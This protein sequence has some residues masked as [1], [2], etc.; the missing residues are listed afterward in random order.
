M[1]TASELV[2]RLTHICENAEL[3]HTM[4]WKMIAVATAN[5]AS[6]LESQEEEI[7]RLRE[8]LQPF[9]NAGSMEFQAS[10]MVKVLLFIEDIER[11]R[12]A[13]QQKE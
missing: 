13:L 6:L 3:I 4:D 8:A 11:A 1:T 12:S 9:A 5:A 2:K 10:G 7:R